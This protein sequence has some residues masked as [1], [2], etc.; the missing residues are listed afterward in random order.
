MDL[1]PSLCLAFS[2][3]P[4]NPCASTRYRLL[5]SPVW[6]NLCDGITTGC[7]GTIL[8][9]RLYQLE[10]TALAVTRFLVMRRMIPCTHF[11][12]VAGHSSFIDASTGLV[13]G[14]LLL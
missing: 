6:A 3:I 2:V 8:L 10:D 1:K 9:F 7:V 4:T 12:L 11:N 5:T 13:L 14:S